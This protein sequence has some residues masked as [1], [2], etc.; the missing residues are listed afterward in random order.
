MSQRGGKAFK[1]RMQS[2]AVP[3]PI[4][5]VMRLAEYGKYVTFRHN[6]G[7]IRDR[8]T[9]RSTEFQK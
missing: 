1:V 9:G 7:T 3:R 8:K 6:G 4:L 2:S 5:S